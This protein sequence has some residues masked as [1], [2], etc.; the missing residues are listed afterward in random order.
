MG[1]ISFSVQGAIKQGANTSECAPMIGNVFVEKARGRTNGRNIL[2]KT[3][4]GAMENKSSPPTP[5]K[6]AP[7]MIINNLPFY[8]AVGNFRFDFTFSRLQ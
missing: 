5:I 1:A 2:A 3:L 4:E 8:A 7:T 6:N